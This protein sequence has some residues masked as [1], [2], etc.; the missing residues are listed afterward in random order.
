MRLD[1]PGTAVCGNADLALLTNTVYHE[2]RHAYQ[3]SQ[4]AIAGNDQD[5][6]FL[7]NAISLAP[8]TIFLDTATERTVCNENTNTTLSLAYHGDSVFDQP[9]APDYAS[10]AWEE[11][12]WVFAAPY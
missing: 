5:G 11:D 2:A 8:T 7:V 3:A 10:Y 6:D 12:A 4:A 1:T 9:Y